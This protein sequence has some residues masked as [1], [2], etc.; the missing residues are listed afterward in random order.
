MVVFS[1]GLAWGADERRQ[2]R[3]VLHAARRIAA[4]VSPNGLPRQGHDRTVKAMPMSP[5][6]ARQSMLQ[7]A[8]LVERSDDE[9]AAVALAIAVLLRPLVLDR[10]DEQ[11]V[12]GAV[13]SRIWDGIVGAIELA[14]PDPSANDLTL[15]FWEELSQALYEWGV[16][17]EPDP[18]EGIP[19]DR[20]T[21]EPLMEPEEY[22]LLMKPYP[23]ES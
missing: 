6:S 7:V 14:G 15:E 5:E 22:A 9:E 10:S 23:D 16:E 17:S 1:T 8:G 2:P 4:H 18:Y 20:E 3:P 12:A 21:G 11:V 19:R 13:A